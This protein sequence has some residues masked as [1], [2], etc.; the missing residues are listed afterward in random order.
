M[1]EL[2][3]AALGHLLDRFESEITGLGAALAAA[4][5]A[6]ARD[7]L[8]HGV[9]GAALTLRLHGTAAAL[10]TLRKG[11]PPAEGAVTALVALAGTEIAAIRQRLDRD[12]HSAARPP[13]ERS[14][15]PLAH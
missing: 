15:S 13:A 5:G 6:A 9:E 2:G 11:P 7:A 12:P 8:L 10:R 14:L 4:G 3:P 1:T